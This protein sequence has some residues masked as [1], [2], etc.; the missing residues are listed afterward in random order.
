MLSWFCMPSGLPYQGTQ[1]FGYNKEYL[2][3]RMPGSFTNRIGSIKDVT[4]ICRGYNVKPRTK[5]KL[6]LFLAGICLLCKSKNFKGFCSVI[7]KER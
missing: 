2:L 7:L 4:H 3:V 5:Q 1:H 6:N